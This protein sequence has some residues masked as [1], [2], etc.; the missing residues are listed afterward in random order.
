M[1]QIHAGTL[2]TPEVTF[3]DITKTI[4]IAGRAYPED[5]RKFWDP[6]IEQLEEIISANPKVTFAF[7]LN[8]HNSGST[9]IILNLIRFCESDAAAHCAVTMLWHFDA[10]DEQTEE[11]GHDYQEVCSRI[12]FQ[13]VTHK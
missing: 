2:K 8:Y 3:D 12:D 13:L 4:A 10:D 11:K 1:M 6:V 5:L 9:R 7:D